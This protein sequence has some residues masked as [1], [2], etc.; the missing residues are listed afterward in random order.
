MNDVGARPVACRGDRRMN[1]EERTGVPPQTN[2]DRERQESD[3]ADLI[4]R[5]MARRAPVPRGGARA[6]A[7]LL[8]SG[9]TWAALAKSSVEASPLLQASYDQTLVRLVHRVS[10][11]FD[12][13]EYDKAVNSQPYFTGYLDYHLNPAAIVDTDLLSFQNQSNK[14]YRDFTDTSVPASFFGSGLTGHPGYCSLLFADTIQRPFRAFG[15]ARQILTRRRL[16]ER[17]VELWSDHFNV[18]IRAKSI[19]PLKIVEDRD[20]MRFENP[21]TG[22]FRAFG[23]FPILLASDSISPAMLIYLDNAANRYVPGQPY[24]ENYA[25]ELFELHTLG[26][27]SQ[28]T[29]DDIKKAS[30]FWA[31]HTVEVGCTP[32]GFLEYKWDKNLHDPGLTTSTTILQ[33]T[34][35]PV[36]VGPNNFPEGGS[37]QAL[38]LLQGLATHPETRAYINA[39]L[40]RW[41]LRYDEAASGILG[42]LDTTYQNT[43]GNITQL[44]RGILTPAT[45]AAI[46]G[47][48]PVRKLKRPAQFAV[49]L[50]RA[51]GG[52]VSPISGVLGGAMDKLN[53]ELAALGH[54]PYSWGPPNGYPDTEAAWVGGIMERWS[55]A[56]KLMRNQIDPGLDISDSTLLALVSG[57]PVSGTAQRLSEVLTGDNLTTFEKTWIQDYVNWAAQRVNDPAFGGFYELL[58]EI[59]ALTAS[60]P[61]YQY[62]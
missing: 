4:R 60:T 38:E 17:T 35:Q 19:G 37:N 11:A 36:T 41:F 12:L 16:L 45:I 5:L 57:V 44:I 42:T 22:Q 56:D 29:E 55:L 46:N 39:K 61:S 34:A 21:A 23:Q 9:T 1:S 40:V 51:V 13:F 2:A 15:T 58:R 53:D 28:Y 47:P 59:F 24:Q 52:T 54:D 32:T 3:F 18:D 7:K 8:A 43:F 30:A 49:G 10:G 14:L 20:V 33:G 48:T 26:A 62:Y 31:G 25:R 50:I 6:G 27:A